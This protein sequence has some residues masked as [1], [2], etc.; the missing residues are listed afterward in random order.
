MPELR[1]HPNSPVTLA[2][3]DPSGLPDDLVV[4]F[5]LVDGR[6]L[7]LPWKAA[8]ALNRL[9]LQPG[10]LF[11]ICRDVKEERGVPRTSY[12][13][14]LPV[15]TEQK[16]VATEAESPL[17]EQLQAS[18]EIVQERKRKPVKSHEQPQLFDRG[19]GTYGPVP[20]PLVASLPAQGRADNRIPMDVAFREVVSFVT[21]ILKDSGEQ[22]SDQSRQD[23]V[24]TVFIS[25]QKL[26]ILKV[27]ERP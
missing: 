3:T 5:P 13:V 15:E 24:S 12:R 9:D 2:L 1:L 16:R 7:T 23:F 14:W 25:A 11:S 8:V 26:G 4:H 20:Q 22:W 19:N 18:I 27:W 21:G 17:T 6:T 10:E